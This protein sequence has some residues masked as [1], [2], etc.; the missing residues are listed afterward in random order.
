MAPTA[1]EK[2]A[3]RVRLTPIDDLSHLTGHDERAPPKTVRRHVLVTFAF[4]PT[5]FG[6]TCLSGPRSMFDHPFPFA[7]D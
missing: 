6:G 4:G 3:C 7:G 5:P 1:S 2:P